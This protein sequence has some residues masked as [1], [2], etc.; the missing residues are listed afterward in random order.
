[1]NKIILS[2][3]GI[4]NVK[5]AKKGLAKVLLEAIRS[6]YTEGVETLLSSQVDIDWVSD[7][8]YSV[9][10]EAVKAGSLPVLKLLLARCGFSVDRQYSCK[11]TALYHSVHCNKEDIIT[12]LLDNNASVNLAD[13]F[14]CSSLMLAVEGSD[15]ECVEQLLKAGGDPK[16]QNFAGTSIL[17]AAILRGH[18]EIVE[19]LLKAGADANQADRQGPL[20]HLAVFSQTPRIMHLLIDYGAHIHIR[21]DM[22]KTA[23]HKAVENGSFRCG[24]HLLE[25]GLDPN[26][27]DRDE[28][29]PLLHSLCILGHTY[30]RESPSS[31]KIAEEQRELRRLLLCHNAD[32]RERVF[33]WQLD[34]AHAYRVRFNAAAHRFLFCNVNANSRYKTKNQISISYLVLVLCFGSKEAALDLMKC[35]CPKDF[36][37]K[38]LSL[39]LFPPSITED[40]VFMSELQAFISSVPRLL[41]LAC[42]KIHRCLGYPLREKCEELALPTFL[43]EIVKM[44]VSYSDFL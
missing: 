27:K 43:K 20:L 25:L 34:T 8:G 5:A 14:G 38:A 13:M 2:L 36:V 18:P 40:E 1:M 16:S 11:M 9:V 32:P 33:T 19:L 41:H 26:V 39:S 17:R 37:G 24:K 35:G 15:P 3:N 12:Y 7:I 21:D 6:G 31:A 22:Q 42:W 10:V 29:S 28:Y 4:G 23:L 30:W 44:E